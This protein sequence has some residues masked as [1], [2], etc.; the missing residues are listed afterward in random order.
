ME[1]QKSRGILYISTGKQHTQMAVESAYSVK[2]VHPNIKVHL[3]TDQ[4]KL[5]CNHIDSI[6]IVDRPHIRSKVD[7]IS[8]SPYDQ[9]LYLDSD[10]RVIAKIDELFD[11]L[12]K[13]DLAL[14]HAH[15]RN[16]PAT[17]E[18]WTMNITTAFPQ[19]NSGVILFNNNLKVKHFF[20]AW[21]TSYHN[22]QKFKDQI[23]LRELLWKSDISFFVLPPEYNIRFKKY[24][25]VWTTEE[26]QPKILH[27]SEFK[28]VRLP[29][30]QKR[31]ASLIKRVISKFNRYKFSLYL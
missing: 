12:N 26:A 14:S 5:N 30:S 15:K 29:T 31:K 28:D 3:F 11:L 20:Q 7:Y 6:S 1:P 22:A 2:L 4:H 17:L 19:L 10:T 16:N 25:S 24:L 9:T 21:A 8:R 23:T 27:F 13:F 18:K